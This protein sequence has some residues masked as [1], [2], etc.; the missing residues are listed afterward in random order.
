MKAW[1]TLKKRG[2]HP[3]HLH[4]VQNLQQGDHARRVEFCNW[5]QDHPQLWQYILFTDE[6]TFTRAGHHNSHNDHWWAKENP[7]KKVVKN[8]QQRFSVNVWC[9]IIGGHLIGPH[10][11]EDRLDGVAY[12]KFLRPTTF[13]TRRCSFGHT[14]TPHF[15]ARRG[16]T[17]LPSSGKA[18]PWPGVSW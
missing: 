18:T 14:S 4:K 2:F 13:T 6:A 16:T 10:I 8:F 9:G 5:L 17:T 15:P 1:R 7:H 11:F 12:A 3:Y